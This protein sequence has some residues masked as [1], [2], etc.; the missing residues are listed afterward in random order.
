MINNRNKKIMTLCF[1]F[2]GSEI[3]LGMKKQGFGAGRWNGFGGKV[4]PGEKIE[5]ATRR[6]MFEEAGVTVGE[7]EKTGILEFEFVKKGEILQVHIYKTE[8]F[9]GEIKESGEMKP[10]WFNIERIPFDKMWP[11]DKYWIPLMLKEKK[12]LGKFDFGDN[13]EILNHELNIVEKIRNEF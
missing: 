7:I 4:N 3:L 9:A 10:E 6:E 11:D 12:F 1:L 13:D 8:D 2:R 5:E